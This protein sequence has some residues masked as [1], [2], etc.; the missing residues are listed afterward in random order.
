MLDTGSL[1]CFDHVVRWINKDWDA[2]FFYLILVIV[3]CF[4][5]FQTFNG[6]LPFWFRTI[7]RANWDGARYRDLNS[8]NYHFS[9]LQYCEHQHRM[10][11]SRSSSFSQ[12]PCMFHVRSSIASSLIY[13]YFLWGSKYFCCLYHYFTC[14]Y[15]FRCLTEFYNNICQYDDRL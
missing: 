6:T 13:I 5:L 4:G 2:F 10:K 12:S 9:F 8:W 7:P 1:K 11:C 15:C 14:Y 3:D